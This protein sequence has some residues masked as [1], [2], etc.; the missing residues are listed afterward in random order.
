MH[1]QFGKFTINQLSNSSGVF[2]GDN[3]QSNFTSHSHKNEGSG[4]TSGEKNILTNNK[5]VVAKKPNDQ[6]EL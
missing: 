3:I 1:I 4:T 5:H 2:S 6:D